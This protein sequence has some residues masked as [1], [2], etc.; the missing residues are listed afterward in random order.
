MTDAAV[1]QMRGESLQHGGEKYS[2]AES[3]GA[4]WGDAMLALKLMCVDPAGIGGIWIGGRRNAAL[5]HWLETANRGLPPLCPLRRVPASISDGRLLGGLDLAATLHAGRP[6]I[7]RGLIAEADGGVLLLSSAEV[8]KPLT[9]AAICQSLDSG[10]TV[11]ER[12]GLTAS[13][14]ARIGVI[15]I[16]EG[17]EGLGALKDRLGIVLDFEGLTLR[18]LPDTALDESL[19]DPAAARAGKALVVLPDDILEALCATACALGVTSL[20]A[21][22]QAVAV[23]RAVA[24]LAG[25]PAVSA[26]DAAIAVRLVL[27]PRATRLPSESEE[28]AHEDEPASEPS[29]DDVA[30]A[31]AR[32]PQEQKDLQD[33]LIAAALA[34]LPKSLLD[35]LA[36]PRAPQRRAA[37]IGR[38]GAKQKVRNHGRRA[39]SKRGDP[40]DGAPLDILETLRAAAPWQ[41]LRSRELAQRPG[42]DFAPRIEVRRQ[43]FRVR[44]FKSQRETL[45]IFAVDASGSSALNRLAEAKGAI[46]LLL[47][48][49]YARRDSVALIA[50]RGKS[51]DLLLP[52]T[53]SLARVK[54]SLAALP[55]G[56]ATPLASA[57]DAARELADCAARKGRSPAL[58]FLT[59]G[60]AN[61]DR[62]GAGVRDRALEDAL[63]A[64]RAVRAAGIAAIVVDTSPRP[65]AASR[66]FAGEMGARYL[67]LPHA[68]AQ[69]LSDAVRAGHS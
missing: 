20:R 5:D 41:K 59:D 32:E 57:T 26:E 66:Q 38:A 29:P 61:V 18:A 64:A 7:E 28:A 63:D 34:Q 11:L 69:T 46:E 48:D 22:L 50:F 65:G 53:R 16:D 6:V 15:A 67:P 55:G 9:I 39:R 24:A 52:P 62:A 37:G 43:D 31:P 1:S 2:A 8:A 45:T 58:V 4:R 12:D 40:R 47:A 54:R 3:A 23:A 60:K 35:G 51:A 68:D 17:G 27:V 21:T 13:F 42:R 19:A 56:G 36:Q 14:S 25:R 44:T 49:C 33:L 10:T 30:D